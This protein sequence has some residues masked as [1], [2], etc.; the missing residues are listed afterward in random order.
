MSLGLQHDIADCQECMVANLTNVRTDPSLRK[1]D[2]VD[3]ILSICRQYQCTEHTKR[4]FDECLLPLVISYAT[5]NDVRCDL[6]FLSKHS[7]IMEDEQAQ[8][9][10]NELLWDM[11]INGMSWVISTSLRPGSPFVPAPRIRKFIEALTQSV[12]LD[13]EEHVPVLIE[14]LL[15]TLRGTGELRYAGYMMDIVQM[16]QHYPEVLWSWSDKGETDTS[17]MVLAIGLKIPRVADRSR[18]FPHSMEWLVSCVI[19]RFYGASIEHM[20]ALSMHLSGA[21]LCYPADA[22]YMASVHPI[23]KLRY[24]D[25]FGATCN[26]LFEWMEFIR[27]RHGSDLT[28]HETMGIMDSEYW[29]Y[30]RPR[31]VATLHKRVKNSDALEVEFDED[32]L[33]NAVKKL[34]MSRNPTSPERPADEIKLLDP[35]VI[36]A[37]DLDGSKQVDWAES[38]VIYSMFKGT[39]VTR[40]DQAVEWI[41]AFNQRGIAQDK[42]IEMARSGFPLEWALASL[43]E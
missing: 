33:N 20:M 38:Q 29:G 28:D 9:T 42:M 8:S 31:S 17:R 30:A 37:F 19:A 4:W 39:S 6:G 7:D 23:A 10:L 32:K 21:I 16:A 40:Y 22:H 2:D 14:H 43:G 15:N 41:T 5:Y 26:L 18:K 3:S 27:S 25:Q 1:Y 34:S 36:A 11:R 35:D 24:L 13:D 12:A